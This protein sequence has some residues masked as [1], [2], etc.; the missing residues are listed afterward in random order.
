MNKHMPLKTKKLTKKTPAMN[1]GLQKVLK[2]ALRNKD[3]YTK[4]V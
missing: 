4:K 1:H 3:N 2:S